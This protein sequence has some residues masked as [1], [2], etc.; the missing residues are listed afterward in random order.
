MHNAR[1]LQKKSGAALLRRTHKTDAKS[2]TARS[3]MTPFEALFSSDWSQLFAVD[4]YTTIRPRDISPEDDSSNVYAKKKNNCRCNMYPYLYPY[5]YHSFIH[6]F[7]PSP[8]QSLIYWMQWFIKL[9]YAALL[10]WIQKLISRRRPLAW[11]CL[12]FPRQAADSLYSMIS[13]R[14]PLA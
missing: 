6:P 5:L 7:I 2:A 3:W 8:I 12:E 4:I 14:R 10:A 1:H 13:R 11:A 9:I